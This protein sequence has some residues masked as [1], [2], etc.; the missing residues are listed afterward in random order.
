MPPPLRYRPNQQHRADLPAQ[1]A[2]EA[3][4]VQE[5]HIVLNERS[6][7]TLEYCE[8]LLGEMEQEAEGDKLLVVQDEQAQEGEDSHDQEVQDEQT[9]EAQEAQQVQDSHAQEAQG[10]EEVLVTQDAQEAQEAEAE[11]EP[12]R[13]AQPKKRPAHFWAD[14]DSGGEANAWPMRAAQPKRFA[15]FTK[16]LPRKKKARQPR[17][18]LMANHDSVMADILTYDFELHGQLLEEQGIEFFDCVQHALFRFSSRERGIPPLPTL[19]LNKNNC[20]H[21]TCLVTPN[22][23]TPN[24]G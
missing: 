1:E 3:E 11:A 9:Q 22:T 5:A 8:R 19:P 23:Q 10:A 20:T 24:R 7:W 14:P 16:P 21:P 18:E 17:T 13:A 6:Q 12:M 2:Q 4:E 15:R